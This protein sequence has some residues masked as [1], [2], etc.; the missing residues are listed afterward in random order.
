VASPIYFVEWK[1]FSFYVLCVDD[2]WVV[3]K[4]LQFDPSSTFLAKSTFFGPVG[5]SHLEVST[6]LENYL[7]WPLSIMRLTLLPG[8]LVDSMPNPE[9]RTNSHRNVQR[10]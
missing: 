2:I 10:L 6:A 8:T 5:G 1:W 7:N 4:S 3:S 9:R